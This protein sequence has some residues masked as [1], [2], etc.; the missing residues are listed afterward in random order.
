M[1][2]DDHSIAV[3][4][5]GG[6]GGFVA[7][8]LARAG[9]E[10]AVVAREQ[11]AAAIAQRGISVDSVR[12]GQ[13]TAHPAADAQLRTPIRFLI[14]ATKALALQH[15]L[16]RIDTQ[17]HLVVPLLNGLDHMAVLRERFGPDHVAAGSIRIEAHRADPGRIVQTSPSFRVELAAD[18]AQLRPVLTELAAQLEAAG[19]PT[20]LGDS[21]AQVLWSKLVRL[22]PLALTTTV[23]GRPLGFVR[24]DPE[25]RKLLE[26]SIAEA[27]EVAN[28]DGAGVDPAQPLAELDAAHPTLS[29]SMQR[30]LAAGRKPEVD[31]IAGAVLR[32]G[33]RHRI[34]C[35]TLARLSR[36]ITE[37]ARLEPIVL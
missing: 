13:F 8:A 19:I 16:D 37:R 3:L 32:A 26:A 25:W 20:R 33:S 29:S 10:V 15:A 30:D 1:P 2:S 24:S 23:S 18:H 28:A 22:C 4:G 7:A 31:A 27:A 34:A 14:V 9:A 6:V 17:P 35:P 36:T 12:L 21:E 5:P 11:T